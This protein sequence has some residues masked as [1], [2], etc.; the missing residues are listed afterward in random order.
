M[1][2]MFENRRWFDWENACHE[3]AGHGGKIAEKL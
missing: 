1:T 2:D 3:S